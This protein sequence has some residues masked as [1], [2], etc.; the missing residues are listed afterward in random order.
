MTS[1]SATYGLVIAAILLGGCSAEI[2]G[3]KV[4]AIYEH[5]KDS[6]GVDSIQT[7]LFVNGICRDGKFIRPAGPK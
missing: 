4:H 7:Y 3:W 1:H 2:P 5:C 6:G